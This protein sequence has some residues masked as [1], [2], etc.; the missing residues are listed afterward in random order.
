MAAPVHIPDGLPFAIQLDELESQ[1][2]TIKHVMP[3]KHMGYWVVFEDS[4]SAPACERP[5]TVG[6]LLA[7][8][9]QEHNE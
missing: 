4:V 5:F 2:G 8:A 1:F 7:Q 3:D 6:Q 9:A